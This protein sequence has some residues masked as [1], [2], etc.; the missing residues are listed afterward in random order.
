MKNSYLL[1]MIVG[2]F[3]L[4]CV[5]AQEED[6]RPPPKTPFEICKHR[7]GHSF[8]KPEYVCA[9]KDKFIFCVPEEG[10]VKVRIAFDNSQQGNSLSSFSLIGTIL[11]RWN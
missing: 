7:L 9:N 11:R 1:A 2:A 6:K 10:K 8:H 3:L 5:S 4:C